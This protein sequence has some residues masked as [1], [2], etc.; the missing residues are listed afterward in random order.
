VRAVAAAA[1][2]L[3]GLLAATVPRVPSFESVK[4]RY[5]RSDAVLLDR[6]GVPLQ[7]LRV[8]PRR[9][10]LDWTPLADA[11]AALQEAVVAAEDRRF[12]SHRGVDARA[13]AA[14]AADTL[15]GRR[16]GGSTITMQVAAQLDPALRGAR[17][18]RTLLQ[19]WRQAR[20]ALALERSWSK[21]QI[22]EAYL[23]L[24]MTRGELRGVAALS[25]GLFGKDPHGLD[26]RESALL[27]A[28][29]REPS[30][31]PD[32]AAARASRV[33]RSRG[34]DGDEAALRALAL[35][36]LTR[37]PAIAPS[38]DAAP[39]A[40]RLLLASAKRGPALSVRSSLDGPLQR[41]TARVLRER[42]RGLD[43]ENVRDAAAL[44][45]DNATGEVL[46]YVGNTGAASSARFVDGA[47][48]RRQAGSTLKPFLYALALERRL[49]TAATPLD[50]SP[51]E[52]PTPRGLFR[53][54][55]YDHRFKG[56]VPA[57]AALAAS[58]N[59]P[60]VR[61]LEL[62]GEDDFVA[63]LRR[64]G[65]GALREASDYGPSLA[66][67]TADVTLWELTAAYRTLA[68]GG[69]TRALTLR[70]RP[71][72]E[73][74]R[75]YSRQA[76]FVAADM[77]SDREAR[78]STF[79]LDSP[80]ATRY[81]TAVKTGTSKDM[82]DNWCVGFSRRY[83]V[84]VWVGNFNG[85][86]MWNVSGITGAAPAWLEIMN[87]LHAAEP[88]APPRPPEGVVRAG[89]EWYLAGTEPAAPPAAD[90]P[91]PRLERPVPGTI[92]ALDP[93]IPEGQQSLEFAALGGRGLLF[94]LDGRVLGPAGAPLDWEPRPG[95]HTLALIDESG[96]ALDAAPFEVRG[97][98]A[99]EN[100]A[101]EPDADDDPEP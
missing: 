77:L 79:G 7:E 91:R 23:N 31:A 35:S 9:R 49:I 43:A 45:V 1:L 70:P 19:K 83:T 88:S 64:L 16:R 46:A 8:D 24:A 28:L 12:Y 60:A 2:A 40:A 22:L 89:G 37:A 13:L 76:A 38:A 54:D 58:I 15:R 47:R 61:L 62:V 33:L 44:V 93:D 97:A 66:L 69:V 42:L 101:P 85:S 53:P 75:A 20:C 25:R 5:R 74:P 36:A 51:L 96:R 55:N 39:E 3:W 95:K 63:R 68:A 72:P 48:A 26:A 86:P 4:A 92:V 14:A 73:G 52:L 65:F 98:L 59:I 30:A 6:R 78:S 11:S 90:A 18:G 17:G 41:F 80:L 84:G 100:G 10:A 57:R 67:G 94:A 71:S 32:R 87:Y 34:G 50:D 29:P 56:P 21:A 82:R 99:A 81:W 27:A